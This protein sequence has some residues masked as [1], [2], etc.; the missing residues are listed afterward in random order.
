MD[1]G[2]SKEELIA[3]LERLLR[4]REGRDGYKQNVAQIKLELKALKG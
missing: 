4:A 1:D 3:K 2:L